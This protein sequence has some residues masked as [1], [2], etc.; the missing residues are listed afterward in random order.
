MLGLTKMQ[1]N[2]VLFMLYVSRAGRC[3]TT[4][5]ADELGISRPFLEQIARKLR[6]S[7]LLVSKRG[8]G[9]G[10]E[11]LGEPTVGQVLSAL[12]TVGMGL[13]P[14][15]RTPES[16]AM[17]QLLLSFGS[18]VAPV[19][20]RKIRALNMELAAVEVAALASRPNGALN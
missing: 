7:G 2:G 15:N 20:R 14:F 8:P 9:G 10:Y 4:D 13:N 19:L 11:I 16:R 6:M 1:Q 18:A 3:R 17:T 5:A 12:G